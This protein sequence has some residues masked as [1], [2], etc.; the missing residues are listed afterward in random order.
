VIKNWFSTL[1][2]M[3]LMCLSVYAW[4]NDYDWWQVGIPFVA[5]FMLFQMKDKLSEQ[6]NYFIGEL[7]KAII[8][9]FKK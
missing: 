4:W 3:S 9:K 8:E 2:G 5:G 6:L 7:F 1:L